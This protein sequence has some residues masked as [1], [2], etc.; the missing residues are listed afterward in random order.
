[1]DPNRL[2]LL[3]EVTSAHGIKGEVRIKTFTSTP[4]DIASYGPLSDQFGQ[5]LLNIETLRVTAKGI[6]A[7]F[8]GIN[9][10]TSAEKLK[11]T[12]LYVKRSQLPPAENG[13]YYHE[14][15][16]GLEAIAESGKVLGLVTGIF[17]FGGGNLIE[18]TPPQ[19]KEKFLI[20]FKDSFVPKVDLQEGKI[21]INPPVFV[22]DFDIQK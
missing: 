20:P 12:K 1:M 13:S 4:E 2:V 19:K 16:L 15:L 14:D 6:I 3:G 18:I 8:K 21:M 7:H 22:E 17:N 9:D 10:R 11:N 5:N